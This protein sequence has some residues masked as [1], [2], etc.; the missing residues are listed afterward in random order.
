MLQNMQDNFNTFAGFADF[1]NLSCTF[2][3]IKLEKE[4]IS[5]FILHFLHDS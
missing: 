4:G 1:H 2:C 3:N 5:R